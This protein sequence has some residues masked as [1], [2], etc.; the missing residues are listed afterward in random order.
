MII[1][2]VL[3]FCC[4]VLHC[5]VGHYHSTSTTFDASHF[6]AL[7]VYVL[8]SYGPKVVDADIMVND[9]KGYLWIFQV[10]VLDA[11]SVFNSYQYC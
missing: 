8:F 6:P 5:C 4:P 9:T 7:L 1:L 2:L 3:L 11:V 10:S